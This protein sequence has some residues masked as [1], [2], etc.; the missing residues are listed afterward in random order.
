MK[1][2]AFWRVFYAPTPGN[3]RE[4]TTRFSVEMESDVENQTSLEDLLSEKDLP[5]ATEETEGTE[6]TDTTGEEASTEEAKADT[7]QET[8][9]KDDSTPESKAEQKTEDE[10]G[11]ESWTKAMGIAERKKRQAAESR[12]EQAEQRVKQLESGGQ[13]TEEQKADWY[14]DPEKAAQAMQQQLSQQ[15]FNTK[16]E[17]SQDM[18]RGQ[19]EDYDD[20][21]T[22]FVDL[23]KQDPRLI[24][25]MQQAPNPARFAY[26]T[27][28]KAREYE[29]M[30]DVD[31]YKAKLKQE[32][33]AELRKELEAEQQ[34][35]AEKQQRKRD[36]IDPS[37]ASSTSNGLKS[38][39]YAGPTPL[40]NILS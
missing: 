35:K 38:D 15:A 22:E 16:L 8:E 40:E 7:E 11:P 28:K 27:A 30:K 33:E 39:D 10:E 36:A 12:A 19:F 3:G 17:L 4:R 18:M 20:L 25:E 1:R 2:P 32:L 37:L 13:P 5:E 6:Q 14:A 26:E 9:E 24:Q 21:E 31:S 23:A 29:A 34:Q